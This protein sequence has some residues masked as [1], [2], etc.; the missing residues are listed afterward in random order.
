MMKIIEENIIRGKSRAETI[1]VGK[2]KYIRIA[3][4]RGVEWKRYKTKHQVKKVEF[5]AL[6]DLYNKTFPVHFA[7]LPNTKKQVEFLVPIPVNRQ[8]DHVEKISDDK[9]RRRIEEGLVKASDNGK[10]KLSGVKYVKEQTGWSLK[11]SKEFVDAFFERKKIA[12]GL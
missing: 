3:S 10:Y 6:E 7:P 2:K 4:S 8:P 11:E 12:V 5:D 1:Q 9:E